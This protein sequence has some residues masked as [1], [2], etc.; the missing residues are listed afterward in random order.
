MNQLD[1]I[2]VYF[3]LFMTLSVFYLSVKIKNRYHLS[4]LNPLLTSILIMIIILKIIKMPAEYYYQNTEILLYLLTPATICLALPLYQNLFLLKK[5]W[6]SLLVG[7]IG[8]VST[9]IF[10]IY[11]GAVLFRFSYTEFVT[12]LPKSITSSIGISLA[13][14]L[15][16][17]ITVTIAIIIVTGV[18]GN[19]LADLM[20]SK[21][22]VKNNL[23]KGVTLGT[24]AHAIGTAKAMEYGKTEGGMASLA[25]VISG[26]VTVIVISA[27]L[28]IY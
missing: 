20:F 15:G 22:K 13:E 3:S 9:N 7:I 10:C 18:I 11:I 17:N 2:S 26:I 8:G 5:Y 28:M 4:F 6:K 12:I 24:T 19:A 14:E 21:I 1:K 16:G 25:L 27:L 23:V